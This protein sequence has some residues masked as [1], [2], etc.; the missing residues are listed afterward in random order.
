MVKGPP[1]SPLYAEV[2]D[3][4]AVSWL[5]LQAIMVTFVL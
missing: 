5:L 1:L 2:L 3:F 4:A